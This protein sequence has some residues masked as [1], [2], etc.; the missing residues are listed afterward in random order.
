M[1]VW[2]E[3]GIPYFYSTWS[4]MDALQRRVS[5]LFADAV[6]GSRGSSDFGSVGPATA[7]FSETPEALQFVVELPGVDPK[8]LQLSVQRRT[9]TIGGRRE[10]EA[11]EGYRAHRRERGRFEFTRSYGLP[12]EVDVAKAQAIAKDGVLTL[13]LPKAQEAQLKQI[14]INAGA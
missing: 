7:H 3:L 2:N 5:A 6:G 14:P 1:S 8:D 4:E 11:P 13:T 9:L 10:V 12:C